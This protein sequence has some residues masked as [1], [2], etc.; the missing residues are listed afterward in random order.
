MLILNYESDTSDGGVSRHA[1]TCWWH[2]ERTQTTAVALLTTL[3]GKAPVLAETNFVRIANGWLSYLND[4]TSPNMF[5]LL[6]EALAADEQGDGWFQ[7]SENAQISDAELGVRV[8]YFDARRGFFQ[9]WWADTEAGRAVVETARRYRLSCLVSTRWT[10]L[11]MMTTYHSM[12]YRTSGNI[13]GSSGGTVNIECYRV[14]DGLLLGSTS[15]VG[16]GAYQIDV[17]VDDDVF[18]EARESSTLLGRSD[19]NT[20][21]RIA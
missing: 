2:F 21:V 15:R 9:R 14:S 18:C 13:T 10:S 1:R 8:K 3:T 4:G 19:N 6:V 16:D 17:P 5:A 12:Y 20:P 11:L 7:V